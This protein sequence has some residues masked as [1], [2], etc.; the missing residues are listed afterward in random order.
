MKKVTIGIDNGVTGS[1]GI[2]GPDGTIF[3][4][5]PTK[6]ALAGKSGKVFKRIDH[7]KLDDILHAIDC[8]SGVQAHA[9]V[10]RAFTGSA[11]MI[12][13]SLLSARS[14]EA[15]LIVLEQAGIGYTVVDS[16]EWQKAILGNVKGSA[17][18]K[19]AS[20]IRGEQLYPALVKEVI[21]KGDADG[22]L[23]ARYYHAKDS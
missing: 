16:K 1:I 7:G 12:N 5:M 9:Y 18:L 15:V 13:T 11:M 17:E 14:H 3:E 20:R 2:I 19:A 6:Q 23:I 10:E 8:T 21:D 22:L 4:P